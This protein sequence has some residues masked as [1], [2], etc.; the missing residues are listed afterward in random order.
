[1]VVAHF[2]FGY[3]RGLWDRSVRKHGQ[4]PLRVMVLGPAAS[5]KT[6]MCEQLAVRYGLPHINVGDLLYDEV[7]R[8]TALGL[9]AKVFM[10]DSKTVPD[11]C[12][13]WD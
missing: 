13:E 10:D 3:G 12:V 1:M 7:A 4:H 11:K 8:K 2:V 5:G 6:V 9:E